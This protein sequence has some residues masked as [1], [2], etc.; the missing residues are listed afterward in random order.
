MGMIHY[1]EIEELACHILGLDYDEVDYN[2][3]E[4]EIIERFNCDFDGFHNIIEL[5]LP[6][7]E[8]GHSPLTET[9]YIGFANKKTKEW[10][11]KVKKEM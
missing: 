10:I 8:T 9:S 4:M 2:E 1:T 5:L 6:T 7:L 3:I 11:I